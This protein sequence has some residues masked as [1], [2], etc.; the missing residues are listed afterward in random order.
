MRASLLALPR[1]KFRVSA[2]RIDYAEA[3]ERPRASEADLNRWSPLYCS[4]NGFVL[5]QFVLQGYFEHEL[6]QYVL[7]RKRM[8]EFLE[9]LGSELVLPDRPFEVG[10]AFHRG[11]VNEISG[12]IR[13]VSPRLEDFFWLAVHLLLLGVSDHE[14]SN[15]ASMVRFYVEKYGL[16]AP[17]LERFSRKD[18][19]G[20]RSA[21]LAYLTEILGAIEREPKTA[22]VI[23]PF[24]EPFTSYYTTFYRPSL[25]RAGFRG[26]RAWGGLG[27]ED[28]IDLL[29]RLIQKVG[30]IWADVSRE[31][32]PPRLGER[33][34]NVLYEIGAAR[35]LGVRVILVVDWAD[36]AGLPANIGHEEVLEYSPRSKDWPQGPIQEF[37]ERLS[38][39]DS[40]DRTLRRAARRILE[41]P[42]SVDTARLQSEW[43]PAIAKSGVETPQSALDRQGKEVRAGDFVRDA[44]GTEYEVKEVFDAYPDLKTKSPYARRLKLVDGSGGRRYSVSTDFTKIDR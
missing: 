3:M 6:P 43:P 14:S 1:L 29:T 31:R 39:T 44:H 36:A 11:L 4:Y 17:L 10:T 35:A 9:E 15:A 7:Q 30:L 40:T 5:G 34:P 28:Y 16:P 27:D 12:I 18:V 24:S 2:G 37:A 22:F 25:E 8:Q 23:M 21:S 19:D 32:V 38:T 20:I 13:D 42:L 41:T 33:N 26:F